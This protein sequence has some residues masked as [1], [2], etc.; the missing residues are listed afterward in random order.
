MDFASDWFTTYKRSEPI[1]FG[2]HV[3][4]ISDDLIFL[5]FSAGC[6]ISPSGERKKCYI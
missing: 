2:S 4:L 3:L 6:Y 1:A 5:A